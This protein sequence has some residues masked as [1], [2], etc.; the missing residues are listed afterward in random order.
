MSAGRILFVEDQ[1]DTLQ[2]YLKVLKTCNL[3]TDDELK[4]INRF[5]G[6]TQKEQFEKFNSVLNGRI[7]VATCFADAFEKIQEAKTGDEYDCFFI[8]RNLAGYSDI[9]ML[10]KKNHQIKAQKEFSQDFFNGFKS[11]SEDT[12]I[13]IGD[14]FVVV[15]INAGVPIEKIYFL[16]ANNNGI[17]EL[18]KSPYLHANRLP[19]YI[20]KTND[21][22]KEDLIEILNNSHCAKVRFLYKDILGNA[23]VKDIWGAYIEKFIAILAKRYKSGA[24]SNYKGDGIILRNMIEAIVAYIAD[25]NNFKSRLQDPKEKDT[26]RRF[27]KCNLLGYSGQFEKMLSHIHTNC[28]DICNN[29]NKK[30]LTKIDES[31]IR[32]HIQ[33]YSKDINKETDLIIEYSNARVLTALNDF[34]FN[35]PY[36]F[37]PKYIFSYIDNIYTVTS[38][39][40]AHGRNDKTAD[41]LSAD[42]WSALLSGMLQIM[43]W[44]AATNPNPQSQQN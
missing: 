9:D 35:D 25:D 19:R 37:P 44:V 40:S 21:S 30:V 23:K 13:F 11:S 18:L 5:K 20:D 17:Q 8:D 39:F 32:K 29:L 34:Y 28:V 42:G 15:L 24:K 2:S 31:D 12:K 33:N 43:Q 27:L 4:E 38:E 41:E 1:Y 14:Y 3:I 36:D 16:T 7:E 6:N 26:V 10:F 22:F